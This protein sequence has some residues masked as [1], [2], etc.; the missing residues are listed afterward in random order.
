VQLDYYV[1]TRAGDTHN[2]SHVGQKA[3]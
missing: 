1:L 3:E 2:L